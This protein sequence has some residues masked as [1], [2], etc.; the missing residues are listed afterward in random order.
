MVECM[1]TARTSRTVTEGDL[2][3]ISIS[4]GSWTAVDGAKSLIM[5]WDREGRLVEIPQGTVAIAYELSH[6]DHKPYWWV[7]LSTGKR[8]RVAAHYITSVRRVESLG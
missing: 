4:T 7:F 6:M 5:S 3:T 8:V 2:V 1:N